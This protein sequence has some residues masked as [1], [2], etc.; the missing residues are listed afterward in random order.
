MKHYDIV[1]RGEIL[2]DFTP[3]GATGEGFLRYIQNPGGAVVNVAAAF[4][5]YG[6][7]A[8]FI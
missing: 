5:K 8:G 1:T 3:D 4:A 2:I 7:K 6:A